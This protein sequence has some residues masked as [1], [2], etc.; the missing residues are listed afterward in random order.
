MAKKDKKETAPTAGLKLDLGCGEV[1]KEGFKGVDLYAPKA[2]FKVDLR[3]YPWPWADGSVDEVFSSHFF[4]HIPGPER[5]PFMDELWRV[6][7]P[8]ECSGPCPVI[9]DAAGNTLASAF[10]PKGGGTATFV[11]PY[12]SSPRAIQDPTHAWPPIHQNTFMYFDRNWK[13]MNKLEHYLGKCSFN[14]SY[15]L[16][17]TPET[18]SKEVKEVQPFW[19]EHYLN[20]VNDIQVLLVKRSER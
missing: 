7:K 13:K 5:I 12:W 17:T 2:D 3:K 10:C 8:C 20:S 6:L 15:W 1:P 11:T 18:A 19:T 4:E 9:K 16:L 14:F